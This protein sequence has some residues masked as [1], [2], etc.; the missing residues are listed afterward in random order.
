MRLAVRPVIVHHAPHIMTPHE[1]PT[2]I[3][4]MPSRAYLACAQSLHCPFF[5]PPLLVPQV[6]GADDEAGVWSNAEYM[7]LLHVKKF[8]ELVSMFSS[9]KG[10]QLPSSTDILGHSED[11]MIVLF[12]HYIRSVQPNNLQA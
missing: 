6:M 1:R 5:S 12:R 11:K 4:P 9:C 7:I 10:H 3:C 2:E 8:G